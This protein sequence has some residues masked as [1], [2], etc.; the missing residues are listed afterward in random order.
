MAAKTVLQ[1][2]Q[3]SY[4]TNWYGGYI[5]RDMLSTAVYTEH[6]SW[7]YYLYQRP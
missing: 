6:K 5:I 3:L 4:Y 2:I 1:T 7:L